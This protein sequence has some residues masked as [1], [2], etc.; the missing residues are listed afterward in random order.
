MSKPQLDNLP[1]E[2]IRAFEAAGRTGSFTRAAA[3]TGLTQSAISQRIGNLEHRVGTPLFLRQPR[4][5]ILTVD[6]ETWLPYV[7]A[8]LHSLRQSSEALFG[9]QSRHLTISASASVIE[10]WLAPRLGHFP[11]DDTTQ[12]SF[13]T[14]ILS[15]DISAQDDTVRIRYGSDNWTHHYKAPLYREIISPVASPDLARAMDHWQ[16]LPRIALSGLRP[17]WSE[18]VAQFGDPATPVPTL[19]FDTFSQALAAARAGLGVLLGSLPLCRY[20][21]ETGQLMRLSDNTLNSQD[22]NWLLASQTALSH[23]HWKVLSELFLDKV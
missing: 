19:R 13:K 11:A 10:L 7:T 8:A 12:I 17:G 22:T 16:A 3:E 18:W 9:I 15:S 4:G 5:V 1:L 21:L 6:G 14:M 2:W 20:E 23:R